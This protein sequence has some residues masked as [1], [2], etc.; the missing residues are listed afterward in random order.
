MNKERFEAVKQKAYDLGYKYEQ[1][2]RGCGQCLLGAISDALDYDMG[3]AFKSATAFAGGVGLSQRSG[4]GAFLGGCMFLSLLKGREKDNFGDPEKV[5]FL[6]FQ[7]ADKLSNKFIAEYGSANCDQIQKVTMGRPYDLRIPEEMSAFD[8][9]GGHL[10]KCPSVVGLA[11]QWVL[12]I[13]YEEGLL[14]QLD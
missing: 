11:A 9:A 3:E 7:L 13:A 12:D 5:R 8:E 2:Y 14:D 1:D 6:S 10:D 4:C